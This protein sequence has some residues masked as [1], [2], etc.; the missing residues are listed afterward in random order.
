MKNIFINAEIKN[1]TENKNYIYDYDIIEEFY[2]SKKEYTETINKIKIPED[3]INNKYIYLLCVYYCDEDGIIY[4]DDII[5]K[6][7]ATE[8][9]AKYD[10]INLLKRISKNYNKSLDYRLY[11]FSIAEIYTNRHI[12]KDDNERMKYY[13]EN[14]D[15]LDLYEL[16]IDISGGYKLSYYDYNGNLLSIDKILY[17]HYNNFSFKSLLGYHTNKFEIGDIIKFKYTNNHCIGKII[18]KYNNKEE[19]IFISRDPYSFKEG[20]NI[21]YTI[22]GFTTYNENW[23]EPY[24]DEDLEKL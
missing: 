23:Q 2:N 9:D 8:K 13:K 18:G 5:F 14:L 3:I 19:N 20:Y 15:R 17:D 22:D 10:G 12:F 1:Y 6:Y 24:Y 21:E 7:Y 11:S 4:K 16:L